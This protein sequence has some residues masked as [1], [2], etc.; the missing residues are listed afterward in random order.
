MQTILYFLKH[1]PLL[2]AI[3]FVMYCQPLAAQRIF[4]ITALYRQNVQYLN[5]A[6]INYFNLVDSDLSNYITVSRRQ[7]WVGFESGSAPNSTLVKFETLPANQ[8][9]KYGGIINQFE[10]GVTKNTRVLANFAYQLYFDRYLNSYVSIGLNAG[11]ANHSIDLS[12]VTK[13]VDPSN[14]DY[15][16]GVSS[17]YPDFSFGVFFV[18]KNKEFG[19]RGEHLIE[20]IYAGISVP[21]I[22]ADKFYLEDIETD[23]IDRTFPV[24]VIGGTTIRLL[25]DV[26]RDLF[27]EPSIWYRWQSAE[28]GIDS[29]LENS[30]GSINVDLAYRTLVYRLSVGVGYQTSQRLHFELNNHFKVTKEFLIHLGIGADFEQKAIAAF[31]SSYEIS[32][33]AAW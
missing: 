19:Y 16:T 26:G 31:G 32:L 4:D 27:L 28:K 13:W 10:A 21:Q 22:F 33:G 30:I 6:A 1:Y 8:S 23:Q 7:Q 2:V 11:I 17:F 5:P 18:K 20:N 12:G 15:G 25:G 3:M 24:Y 29:Y 14:S 9:L